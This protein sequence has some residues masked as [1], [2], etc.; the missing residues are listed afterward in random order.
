LHTLCSSIEEYSLEG[1]SEKQK[2]KL[3][4]VLNPECDLAFAPGSEGREFSG[5]K[6]VVL[7]PGTLYDLNETIPDQLAARPRTELF[8]QEHH[9]YRIIWD[10]KRVTTV[11]YGKIS[12]WIKAEGF[13]RDYRLRQIYALQVQHDF[14]AD[15]GRVGPPI[16]P[17]IFTPAVIDVYTY[18]SEA[19]PHLIL[20]ELQ[21]QAAFVTV[22]GKTTCV[23]GFDFIE[24]LCSKLCDVE[25]LIGER[26]ARLEQRLIEAS[27]PNT[28]ADIAK[29]PDASP[30][31][32]AERIGTEPPTIDD[33][34]LEHPGEAATTA[35]VAPAESPL[36]TKLKQKLQKSREHLRL[37][38][39]FRST[40]S[41]QIS[42]ISEPLSI[43]D[44][45]SS[46]PLD[47]PA[48]L[49]CIYN[50]KTVEKGNY[51]PKEPIILRLSRPSS[52]AAAEAQLPTP[53]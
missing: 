5:S 40:T 41:K 49:F 39:D 14:I 52:E 22:K 10:T 46:G 45:K 29:T 1:V 24:S 18:D 9:T 4:M 25:R 21:Q 20:G 26:V 7:I 33:R 48:G 53:N 3:Y 6:S 27:T 47:V 32:F 31:A 15:F 38:E 44:M 23:L 42:L 8:V 50:E 16:A 35:D 11:P 12:D 36:Q 37:V 17:P 43:P 51:L 34:D 28:P 13:R 2:Q 19:K 30:G